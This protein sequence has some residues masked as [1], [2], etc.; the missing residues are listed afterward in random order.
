MRAIRQLSLFIVA[1][2]ALGGCGDDRTS[3]LGPGAA[4]SI[5][6]SVQPRSPTLQLGQAVALQASVTGTANTA[7]TWSV[8]EQGSAGTVTSGGLYTAPGVA[9]TFHIRAVSAAD[10]TVFGE[11]TATVQPQPPTASPGAPFLINTD[12]VSGSL[13][14]G[15]SNLGGYLS[16]FGT[17]F[18]YASTGATAQAAL[19]SA[20]GARVWLRRS[21]ANGGD[22]VWREVA[23]YRA[24]I[25]SRVYPRLGVEQIIV[26]LGGLGGQAAGAVLDVKVTVNGVDSNVLASQFTVQPG[27]F[28]FV[29]R[30]ASMGGGIAGNDSTG[31]V[32]DITHPY[33]YLQAYGSGY[34]GIFASIQP[35][36][37]IVLR[38]MTSRVDSSTCTA[39]SGNCF[40]ETPGYD[41]RWVRFHTFTGNAPTGAA[42][43]GYITITRYPGPVM[44]HAPED[45]LF[46]NPDTTT[47]G[48]GIHGAG[49]ANQ[50]TQGKYI[51][52]S[53]LRGESAP[54]GT[55]D[56]AFIYFQNGG[57]YWRVFDNEVTW[58][59]TVDHRAGGATG[60]GTHGVIVANYIHDIGGSTSTY[61]NH[62]IYLSE[63]G[64]TPVLYSQ[65]WDI[66]YN[67]L[68]NMTGGSCFQ[69]Y[70]SSG[71]DT[72]HDIKLHHN[73]MEH[74]AK[75]GINLS[76]QIGTG[77]DIYDNVL[78][79]VKESSGGTSFKT[80]TPT[81]GMVVNFVHN[82]VV[83][84][85]GSNCI[86]SDGGS[87]V[88]ASMQ[89]NIRHN[90]IAMGPGRSSGLCFEDFSGGAGVHYGE[91]LWY[92]LEP[93][94][95][96]TAPST[97]V[98][99]GR[100]AADP[101]FV[102]NPTSAT[103]DDGNYA[104]QAASPARGAASTANPIAVP[105]DIRGTPR[106]VPDAS[107][108]GTSKNDLG[109]FE[110]GGP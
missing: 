32:N 106:P 19:G 65:Y 100:V 24:L 91:N 82:T 43:H 102:K 7:V 63:S 5:S 20:S 90:I 96:K 10:P 3:P 35:G 55:N 4:E 25:P 86:L 109:A 73:W 104:L 54:N 18:G 64:G 30:S 28:F 85:S 98:D 60:Q 80:T 22:N 74:C 38:G 87:P 8:V 94:A 62:G 23:N 26:Q 1:V 31:V 79:D 66:A 70:A 57:D 108:P 48:G 77:I 27:R 39:S 49:G 17:G 51:V 2:F 105:T 84:Y 41:N 99:P 101:L 58:P 78:L 76:S 47:A 46:K 81:S 6:V 12:V 67:W 88:D 71:S 44:G 11:S 97:S 16:L 59:T 21:T 37:T 42:N 40:M 89:L 13:T 93:S 15:E 14:G 103:S 36:D 50:A 83:G 72:F 34:S 9:G 29:S 92:D 110:Y 75:N 107:T 52:V 45:V 69:F 56:S 33:R 61:Q 68:A 53:G 95:R